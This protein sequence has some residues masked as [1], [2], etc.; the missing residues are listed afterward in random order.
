MGKGATVKGVA[1][2]P[3]AIDRRLRD[4]VEKQFTDGL[5]AAIVSGRYKPGEV[6]PSIVEFAQGLGVSIRSPQAALKTLAKE[7]LSMLQVGH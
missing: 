7:G 4:G 2:F 5:R 6:L 1:G 3:F